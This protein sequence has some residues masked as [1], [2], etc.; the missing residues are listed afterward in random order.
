[1]VFSEQQHYRNSKIEE[2]FYKL[3]VI[4]SKNGGEW[5][6]EPV[7]YSFSIDRPYWLNWIFWLA[8]GLALSA[9]ITAFIQYRTYRL[10][11][12][13]AELEAI[14]KERTNEIEQQKA[15]IEHSRDEVTKYAKDITD[16]IKY[17]RRIQKAI[18][19]AIQDMKKLLPES[20]IFFKSK[21]LVSGDFYFAE[22]IG[23]KRIF[24][25]VD[26][27]GHGVPGGF[28]SIVANNLL[29]QS[30]NQM[31]LTKPSEILEFLNLGVTNTL[32]QTYEESSIKD[33]MDIALCC[34]D[35][36][37]S[38]LE[39]AGAYNPLYIFRDGEL[40][41]YKGNRFPVGTFVG[42]KI[43]Q[44]TNHTIEVKKGDMIYVFSDGFADQFGGPEGKKFKIRR[45]KAMLEKIHTHPV[46]EQL[47]M[48]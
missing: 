39:F 5:T 25:A 12:D 10:K 48:V 28:M 26:C 45:F 21:D 37:T 27:T 19:P 47:R 24:C 33:G 38:T 1:M 4:A 15:E 34:W 29:Q 43:R 16:S 7:T 20:F 8:I 30:V 11:T 35:E 22:K 40:I 42:E 23:S 13:M 18:F 36:K 32:H 41:E 14:V 2:G 6:P 9:L 44:F 3:N 31:G 17:A 46:D